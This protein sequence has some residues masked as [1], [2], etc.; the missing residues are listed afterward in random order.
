MQ[1][2]YV[3]FVFEVRSDS[4]V[5]DFQDDFKGHPLFKDHLIARACRFIDL[6]VC[7]NFERV[8]FVHGVS[9]G[10]MRSKTIHYLRFLRQ[11]FL[12]FLHCP[13][14]IDLLPSI[15]QLN[16]REPTVSKI[17]TTQWYNKLFAD[18]MSSLQFFLSRFELLRKSMYVTH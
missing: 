7:V 12:L 11:T 2:R 14:S 9:D 4:F 6:F 8:V 16:V 3:L 1:N 13:L 17:L 15:V 18:W 10:L 5:G